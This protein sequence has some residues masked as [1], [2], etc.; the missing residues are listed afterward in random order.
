MT[1]LTCCGGDAA[2]GGRVV[3]TIGDEIMAVFPN[4]RGGAGGLRNASGQL[5]NPQWKNI[6]IAIRIGFHC[7]SVLETKDGDVFGDNV[8]IAARMAERQKRANYRR[9]AVKSAPGHACQHAPLDA[10]TVKGK[11]EDIRVFEVVWQEKQERP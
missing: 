1:A 5:R 10:L 3:K 4:G 2:H 9:A 7:G 8:N 11:T 6:R